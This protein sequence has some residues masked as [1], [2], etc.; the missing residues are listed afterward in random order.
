MAMPY[1]NFLSYNSTGIDCVK[2]DWVR[3]IIETCDI[4]F[5]QIQEHFKVTKSTTTDKYF[6]K[7]FRES[8]SYLI[9]AHRDSGQDS[10]RAKGGLAQIS[11]KSLDVRKEIISTKSFRLQAQILNFGE[12]KLLWM[13]TYFP[14]DPQTVNFDQTELLQVQTEIEGILNNSNFDDVLL[15]CKKNSFGSG[16][17][18]GSSWIYIRIELDQENRLELDIYPAGAGKFSSF[19]TGYYHYEKHKKL[20]SR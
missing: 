14:T 20:Y 6:K 19:F 17:L 8:D 9:P 12:F 2:T 13:N 11:D 18:S 3:T 10:G 16:C 7:E 1:V 4:S 5:L 15:H